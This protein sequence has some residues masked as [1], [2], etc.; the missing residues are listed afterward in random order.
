M[1]RIKNFSNKAY[2]CLKTDIRLKHLVIIIAVSVMFKLLLV[3]FQMITIYPNAAPVDDELMFSAAQSIGEGNWLGEYGYATMAK[4]MF[5]SVWLFALNTLHIPYL[6]GGQLLYL[7]A[8][9][10]CVCATRPLMQKRLYSLLLFD[11][12]WFSPISVAEY[13]TRVYIDNIYSSVCLLFFA[14]VIGFALRFNKPFKNSVFYSVMAG[15]SLAVVWLTKDDG[16]WVLPFGICAI[17]IS[18]I[19]ILTSKLSFVDKILKLLSPVL[20]VVLFIG[21]IS[22]YK[23]Q[24]LE[25]Y[26]RY[27]ISD[28]TSDEFQDFIGA[29]VA[30]D[31]NGPHAGILISRETRL[32]L[33]DAIPELA[34]VGEYLET[35]KYYNS[36]GYV[37]RQELKS[38]GVLWA[39]R[40]AAFEA[41][42]ADTPQK[43]EQF[44]S[45]MTTQIYDAIAS[46]E[47]DGNLNGVNPISATL[48]PFDYR[49]ILPTARE[50]INSLEVLVNFQQ[51]STLAPLSVATLEEAEEW[52][53]YT[54]TKVSNT[55]IVNSNEP[56]YNPLEL[57]VE[58]IYKVITSFYRVVVPVL[59]VSSFCFLIKD[60][61][62]A[63]KDLKNKEFSLHA[64]KT[65][66]LIGILLSIV[67]RITIISYIEISSF[68]I[69][70][71]LMY[72]APAGTL[73]LMFASYSEIKFFKRFVKKIGKQDKTI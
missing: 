31:T 43:A 50:M 5:F 6:I 57:L 52:G 47:I 69:G 65:I 28:Y 30:A 46:G 67:L 17:L 3:S 18:L 22:L 60:I 37:D 45:S 71:D 23:A 70:T 19:F 53:D 9:L 44:Y 10:L 34:A 1:C 26:G 73:L 20:I 54:S 51:T 14:A 12:L 35:D 68:R 32:K 7:A 58:V 64:I 36:V 56:F 16:I 72:L 15:V 24:N 48:V 38:G 66:L 4:H 11:I 33:Y 27:I 2:E 61:K 39:I 21:G 13:T 41:G 29:M 8:V 63:F 42:F 62:K 25:H 59:L 55:A 49:Y 40:E